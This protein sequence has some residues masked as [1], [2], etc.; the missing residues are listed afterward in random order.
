M[1]VRVMAQHALDLALHRPNDYG[2]KLAVSSR[3]TPSNN[4]GKWK[5]TVGISK[6]ESLSIFS[7]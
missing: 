4:Q 3:S 6:E 2:E 5:M 7:G 1:V